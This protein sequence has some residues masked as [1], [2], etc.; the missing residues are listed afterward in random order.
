MRSVVV[1]TCS[2][3][4]LG[5][6]QTAGK[7]LIFWASRRTCPATHGLAGLSIPVF[8]EAIIL[9]YIF[10]VW[11]K[12]FPPSGY[13]PFLEDPILNLKMVVMPTFVMATHGMAA[14]ARYVRSSLLEVIGQDFIQ[15]ARAKGLRERAVIIRHAFKPAAIPV[16]KLTC[17]SPVR[18][19]SL[20]VMYLMISLNR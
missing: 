5:R 7:S 10:A 20:I 2:K 14:V 17:I 9:I 16:K 12:I 15:T 8:W 18:I 3:G 13:V 1:A 6:G 4:Y 19:R 11:W